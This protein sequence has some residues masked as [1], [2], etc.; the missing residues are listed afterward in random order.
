MQKLLTDNLHAVCRAVLN[1]LKS[2]VPGEILACD[3]VQ[4]DHREFHF[5]AV[6]A[7]HF[8]QGPVRRLLLGCEERLAQHFASALSQPGAT[9]D[10]NDVRL[11]LASFAG[12]VR[13]SLLQ[14]KLNWTGDQDFLV[15][16]RDQFRVLCDGVRNFLF[17]AAVAEGRLDLIIDLAPHLLGCEWLLNE[18]GRSG[19]VKVGQQEDSI[20]DPQVVHRI[21]HHLAEA[22]ADVQ[23]KVPAEQ[24]RLELLQA[25]FLPAQTAEPT[26]TLTLTCARR[27]SLESAEDIPEKVTLVFIVQDKLLQCS[28]NVVD[29]SH[30]WLDD[31]IALPTLVLDYPAA[32][33]YGQRRGAFRLEPPERILGTVQRAGESALQ[34]K[35]IPVRVQDVSYTGAKLL[36]GA[37]TMVSSFKGGT[38]VTCH[39]ELPPSF[40]AISLRAI[41]RRLNLHAEDHGRRGASLGVEFTEPE[42]SEALLTLRRYIKDRHAVRLSRGSAELKIG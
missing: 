22:G 23:V 36:I 41:V 34:F 12:V 20:T 26:N 31:D 35:A 30:R 16:D 21:M 32:V 28:C 7:A 27:T 6:A 11:G 24:D 5:Q 8:P 18:I 14:S 29:H 40:G 37:N 19:Q 38:E 4:I 15:H 39:L 33:T 10:Q 42:S 17:R 1:A 9:G 3:L 25:T 13:N 2:T